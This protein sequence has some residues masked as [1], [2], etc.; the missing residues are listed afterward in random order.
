MTDPILRLDPARLSVEPGRQATLT[1]T[2]TNPGTIVEGYSVDVVSTIPMPWVEVTPSTLSVYP[3][4]E[5]T[6]VIVVLAA[7][8]AGRAGWVAPVRGARVVGGRGRWQRRRRG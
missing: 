2:V 5:A 1:L 4:Q 6:A 3:Q 8:R 7:V